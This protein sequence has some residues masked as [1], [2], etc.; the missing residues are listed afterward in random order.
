MKTKH[1]SN[2]IFMHSLNDRIEGLQLL[3]NIAFARAINGANEMLARYL[4]RKVATLNA[5]IE[6]LK[7]QSKRI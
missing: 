1:I 5:Q 6:C 2:Q 4:V 7:E 3:S